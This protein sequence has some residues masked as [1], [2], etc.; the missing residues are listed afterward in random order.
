MEGNGLQIIYLKNNYPQQKKLKIISSLFVDTLRYLLDYH[1]NNLLKKKYIL[2]LI[3][4]ILV[5]PITSLTFSLRQYLMQYLMQYLV[6]VFAYS[7]HS[8]KGQRYP[9]N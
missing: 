3:P 1:L 5:F 2:K 8:H 9:N 4:V 7:M 6:S